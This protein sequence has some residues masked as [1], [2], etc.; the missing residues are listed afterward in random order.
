MDYYFLKL[1][2]H[3]RIIPQK[4]LG[5]LKQQ[6]KKIAYKSSLDYYPRNGI[7]GLIIW[8]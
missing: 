6:Q 4:Y 2:L 3:T 7:S 8:K 1:E 5:Y